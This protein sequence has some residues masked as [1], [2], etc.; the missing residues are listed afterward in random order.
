MSIAYCPAI[1]LPYVHCFLLHKE[2]TMKI[3]LRKANALQN[4]IQDHVKTI[5]VKTSVSLNEFQ[6]A[7]GEIACARDGVVANDVRRAKL[8][9]ALYR[10]RAT[11]GRAN[12]ESGVSDLLAEAAYVD[13]RIGHLKGLTE[14]EAAEADTVVT[15]KLK[16]LSD[17]E[18]KS[19]MY[20]YSDT[21]TTGVLTADQLESYK[22]DMRDL[23][24]EKQSINDK[25]LEL[26]VRTEIEVDADTVVLLQA[27]Q[28]I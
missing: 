10:I 6:N 17:A 7:T 23:K 12:V 28:L 9:R 14:C 20:G 19:R 24:K 22:K 25:V 8:T 3:T 26:N 16:K 5:E 15:G 11:V 2:I 21:V 1:H 18:A 27:E 4:S 13:K